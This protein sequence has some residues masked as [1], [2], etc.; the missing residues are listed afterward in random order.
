M[1]EPLMNRKRRVQPGKP[2]ISFGIIV[3]NGMPYVKYNLRQLYP[4]AHEIIVVEGGTVHAKKIATKGGHSTDGTLQAIKE[5]IKNEDGEGKVELV[6]KRGLWSEKDEQSEAYAKRATGDY[7]WQVDVDEFYTRE[8]MEKVA[9]LLGKDQSI[10]GSSFNTITFWGSFS[11]IC[12]GLYLRSGAREYA[13]L[14]RW[15]KGFKYESHRPPTVVD[16]KGRNLKKRNWLSGDELERRGVFLYHYSLLLP[17]QV[18][19]KIRYYDSLRP[20]RYKPVWWYK[21]NYK[22][23]GNPFRVHNVYMYPSWLGRFDGQHPEE[24]ARLREDMVS[25]KLKVIRRDMRDVERLLESPWYKVARHLLKA[26]VVLNKMNILPVK[27]MHRLM[28]VF[29]SETK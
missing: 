28:E 29:D 27:T 10:A 19:D 4:F 13:R 12:D 7:L 18:E 3:F 17:K 8:S 9:A 16:D 14:F 15:G 25:G 22:K 24:I 21:N 6:T 20:F 5:F 11:V 26:G 23:I 1:R 2:K